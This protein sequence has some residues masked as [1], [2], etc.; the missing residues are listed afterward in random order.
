MKTRHHKYQ[1]FILFAVLFVGALSTSALGGT[2]QA[3]YL[4]NLSNFT[5]TLPYNWVRAY[6]DKEN[7]EFYVINPSDGSVR[8]FNESGMEIYRFGDDYG[9]GGIYDIAVD[10]EGNILL[11]SHKTT[12]T[13]SR[14]SII[15]CNYRGE[16][17]SKIE[18]KNIPPEFSDFLPSRLFYKEESLYLASPGGM[19]VLVVGEE[20]NFKKSFDIATLL[21]L[22]EGRRVETG[23]FGF[24]VDKEGNIFFTVPVLFKAYKLSPNGEITSFGRRGSQ[25]G[26]FN[27]VSGIVTDDKGYIYI[28]DTLRCVVMIFD[29]DFRFQTE[30]GYRGFKPGNLIAP[31]E[32]AVDSKGNLYVTQSRRRGVSVYKLGY[33]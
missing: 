20:G 5:G 30:F 33:E 4:Y 28:A 21:E 23:I 3:T 12:D 6:A 9:L 29:R 8:I 22:S 24:S 7:N 19:R 26:R 14:Y 25:P 31:R 10:K 17:I 1:L 32:L 16:P 27:I 15:R 11:L 18:M 2:I 13:G